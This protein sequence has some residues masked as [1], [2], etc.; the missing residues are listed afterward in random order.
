MKS[1]T[2]GFVGGGRITAILLHAL[3]GR[4]LTLGRV[5]VP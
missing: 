5:T 4:G 1:R 3:G 2:V